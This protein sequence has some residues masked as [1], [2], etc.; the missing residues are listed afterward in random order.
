MK[1]AN[2]C[3]TWDLLEGFRLEERYERQAQ[4]PFVRGDSSGRGQ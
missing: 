1:I 3:L 2:L 4:M